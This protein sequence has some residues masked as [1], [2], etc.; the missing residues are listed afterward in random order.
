MSETD[1]QM[2]AFH[3]ECAP[4]RLRRTAREQCFAQNA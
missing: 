4:F 2:G 1:A 3:G